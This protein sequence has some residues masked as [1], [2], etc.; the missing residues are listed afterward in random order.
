MATLKEMLRDEIL[1]TY[2]ATE[3]L[4][5]KVEPDGL[6]WKPNTGSNW[7][8]VGQLLKH[9][10]EACGMCIKGFVTGDWGMPDGMKLEDLKPEDMLPP[11]EKLPSFS[12]VEEA[13]E[14]LA[15]DKQIA[16]EHLEAVSEEDLHTTLKTAPWGGPPATLGQHILHMVGHLGQHKGQLFYY[17]KLQGQPVHTGDL[18]GM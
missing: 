6:G 8:T 11:A 17:L 14:A 12:C 1:A 2:A 5:Q 9:I 18:W 7:M 4:I 13:L 15:I 10:T 16:L 3:K